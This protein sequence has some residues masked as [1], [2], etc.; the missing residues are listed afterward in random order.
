MDFATL[1][2]KP[3]V[4]GGKGP[5][6]RLRREGQI[7]AVAYGRALSS[8]PI[9]IDPS[10]LVKILQ[11][12]K[13][14]N[15]VMKLA[16]ESG[17]GDLLVMVREFVHH[18]VTRKFV[19]ADFIQVKLEEDVDVD[20]PLHATGKAI[21]LTQGGVVNQIY[22]KLPIRTRPNN[23]PAELTIDIAHLEMG[24]AVKVQDLKLPEGVKVRLPLDQS[25]VAVVAPEKDRTAE[26][27]AA[28]AAAA[29]AAAGAVPGAP[30]APGAAP[31]APGAPGAAAAAGGK[32]G[33]APAA[34]A[35]AAGAPAAKG[36]EKAPAKKK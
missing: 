32:P 20:V 11:G 27:E 10:A 21:G 25:I 28:E 5:A 33:A 23:I 2:A 14:L 18:P 4:A 12:P 17:A 34:G 6:R 16:I 15:T 19:H 26:E 9:A 8:T 22:R 31:G 7:P 30:G 3:R 35:P 29:A 24:D 13:G 36:A 1:N